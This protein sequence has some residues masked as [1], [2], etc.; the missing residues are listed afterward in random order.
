[1]AVPQGLE[2]FKESETGETFSLQNERLLK[3]ELAGATI[4]ARAGSMVGYQGE[5]K[6]EHA[7]SGGFGRMMKR[8]TTGEGVKL[9]KLTGSGEVFLADHA[10]EVHLVR[11]ADEKVTVASENL[12]AFEAGIDWNIR[13]VE[14][15][16]A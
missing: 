5:V 4:Q 6:F 8:V 14:G 12:L 10:Q 1:M 7:G 15:A 11:L 3:V 2:T 16:R 13:K 9:M